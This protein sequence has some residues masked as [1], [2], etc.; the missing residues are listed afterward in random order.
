MAAIQPMLYAERH[1]DEK[2][3]RRPFSLE[4]FTLSGMAKAAKQAEIAA[5]KAAQPEQIWSKIGNLMKGLGG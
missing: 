5:E 4:D 3:R 1:R 2:R